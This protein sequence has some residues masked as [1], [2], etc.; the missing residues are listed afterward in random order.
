[1][2]PLSSPHPP[3]NENI[4]APFRNPIPAHCSLN[5]TAFSV[6]NESENTINFSPGSI[7]IFSYTSLTLGPNS[8]GSPESC[9]RPVQRSAR[10]G[11]REK[12]WLFEESVG[13]GA[14][15]GW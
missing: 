15:G 4:H 6:L 14:E 12:S 1:L 11:S 8:K 3:K 13:R 10:A 5:R 9:R 7:P 2:T